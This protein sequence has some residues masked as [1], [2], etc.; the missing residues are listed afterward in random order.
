MIPDHSDADVELARPEK[1]F[2][3]LLALLQGLLLYLAKTGQEHGWWPFDRLGGNVVWYTLVLVV[4]T[5]M[6]LSVRRLG[7]ARFWQHAAGALALFSTL[8]AWAVWSAT[9]AD[10][11]VV[12]SGAVLGPFGCTVVVGSFVLLPYLQARLAQGR[13]CA[14][15][16][17]LFEVAWQNG[18]TLLLTTVFVGLG[19]GLLLLWGALFKL[20]GIDF[21]ARLFAEAPFI[22]L[23]TGLLF[24][25]GILIGRTQQRPVRIARFIL[26]A[27]FTGL[28]PVLLLFS[29]LFLAS[30]PF[31]GLDVLW[32][33]SHASVILALLLAH[34]V[35]FVHAV[36][37]DAT[38][39]SPYPQWLRR[40]VSLG[41]LLSPVFAV[42]AVVALGLRIQQYG[43]TVDR[44]WA[45]V[46]V[47]LL[48]LYVCGYAW[49]VLRRRPVWLEA[50]PRVNVGVSLLLVALMVAGNSPV[51]D[52]FRLAVNSQMARQEAG[53]TEIDS[54]YLRWELGRRGVQAL[55]ELRASDAVAA[56]ADRAE[57]IDRLLAADSRYAYRMD[58]DTPPIDAA[59]A[60]ERLVVAPGAVAPD[61]AWLDAFTGGGLTVGR[62]LG[63]DADCLVFSPDANGD[64]VHEHL[65]CDLSQPSHLGC[66]L[67]TRSADGA[68]VDA[69]SVDWWKGDDMPWTAIRAGEI[70]VV[71]QCWHRL[72]VGGLDLQVVN[73]DCP[74][75]AAAPAPEAADT[76]TGVAAP[77]P[78][79]APD[80]TP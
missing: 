57:S 5:L 1:L 12:E 56:D 41:L 2:I 29:L 69:G 46:A 22:Y 74:D 72:A 70:R 49:A 53:E 28:L 20:I 77:E 45:S 10:A 75:P 60:R 27:L 36:R 8:A 59:A 15:Y 80:A 63:A 66:Q 79:T 64:G 21:F 6:V 58:G 18:L 24:G 35:Q 43:W 37:Q 31:T 9:S 52:P 55:R 50:L 23:A 62:C 4:P 34:R 26:F 3:V 32:K 68:W 17:F 61:A 76:A 73:A 54:A 71:P 48:A 51:L 39:P 14:P 42:L 16:P 7:D 13:W 67:S 47:G 25:L 65:L 40:F 33:T 44:F 19:W 78:A 11:T 38:A 30:L